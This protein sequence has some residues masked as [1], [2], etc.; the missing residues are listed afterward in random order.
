MAS[1]GAPAIQS[2]D[3][4]GRILLLIGSEPEPLSVTALAGRL[5]LAKST[6]SRLLSSLA[7]HE[8]VTYDPV[9]RCYR[10]GPALLRLREAA[11][12]ELE[13]VPVLR[14]VL[15]RLAERTGATVALAVLRGGLVHALEQ[16]H[17]SRVLAGAD[18]GGRGLP[19]HASASGKV[20]LAS[21]PDGVREAVLAGGLPALTARSVTDPEVLRDELVRVARAGLAVER[22]E[23]EEGLSSLAAP[24]RDLDDSAWAAVSAS[25]PSHRLDPA[26][27]AAL[28]A[29]L[30][31]AAD[32]LSGQL[33]EARIPRSLW[34]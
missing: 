28:G 24:V 19:A 33:R 30:S 16:A 3:R 21:A 20:L 8:L 6:V 22:D 17:G 25:V 18:V 14:P 7:H 29:E 26:R 4:A 12:P 34:A 1:E 9:A 23:L 32:L 13:L 10:L 5:G 15:Q 27:E 31:A 2:V 11:F